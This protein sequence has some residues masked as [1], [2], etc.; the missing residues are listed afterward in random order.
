MEFDAFSGLS[1]L[2]ELDLSNCQINDISMDAFIG[3]KRLHIINLSYN[4]IS[5]ITPGLFDDQ[6]N[7][8][9]IY[10]NNNQL[11]TLPI[12]FF[13]QRSLMVA[14]LSDNPWKC[15]CDMANWK[16]K[17]TN[18]E[19][20]PSTERCVNDYFSGKK[21][22]CRRF[23]SYK[24]NKQL[25]PRCENFNRR[26][27][28]Y[29]MRKQMQ[30]GP[31]YIQLKS[32]SAQNQLL[33]HWRKMEEREQLLKSIRED[34]SQLDDATSNHLRN[35]MIWQLQRQEKVKTTLSNT[36]E[37]S[38]AYQISKRSKVKENPFDFSNNSKLADVPN[39]I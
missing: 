22:S 29:V 26:S 25:A 15:S 21:L 9:E 2:E 11:R 13:Q 4:N 38:L 6:P 20:A 7:L 33:P 5:Y 23:K 32:R 28:Y 16:A 30:C 37:N 36:H 35:R 3:C 19:K 31:K 1:N 10:L 24:F 17:I 27:V 18:Q 14:R 12:T 39:D 34:P 8:E